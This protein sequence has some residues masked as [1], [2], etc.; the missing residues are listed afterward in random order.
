MRS[1]VGTSSS[2]PLSVRQAAAAAVLVGLAAACPPHACAE[3]KTF[4]VENQPDGYGIDECLASGASC[5]RPMAST[6]CQSHEYGEAVSFHRAAP[7]E[8]A[9]A[10]GNAGAACTRNGCLNFIAIECQR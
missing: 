2:S 3:T 1:A 6:F 4:F 10:A 7:E 8:T 5:G 9:Q